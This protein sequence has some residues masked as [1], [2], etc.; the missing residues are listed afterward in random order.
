MLSLDSSELYATMNRDSRETVE[1]ILDQGSPLVGHRLSKAKTFSIYNGSVIATR[2]SSQTR[3]PSDAGSPKNGGDDDWLNT[4]D[5]LVLDVPSGFT[6]QWRDSA[7]FVMLRKLVE[8]HDTKN[9]F[10]AYLSGFVLCV[11]LV[12]VALSILPLFTCALS[13]IVA[14]V[15]SRCATPESVKKAVRLNVVLTIVGAFGIGAA[16]GKHG[17]AA[18]LANLLVSIFAPFG[19]IGLL[20]AIWLVVVLLGVIFHGTAVVALMFPLCHHVATAAGI[21][22]HQMIAILCYSVACQ[23]LSP[24]SYNT[25]LM[26]YAACPDYKFADFTKV[27]APLCVILFILSVPMCQFYWPDPLPSQGPP[28]HPA[29]Q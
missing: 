26:A 13:A 16:I 28:T 27:G 14:L 23:M 18:A 11:M 22:L 15:V 4:G 17:V 2:Q 9:E 1:V 20:C 29:F 25:N 24:V 3:K 19:H 12:F 21:P 8:K 6:G 10:N 7:D 5:Q